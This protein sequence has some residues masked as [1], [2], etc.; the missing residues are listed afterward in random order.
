MRRTLP[1]L[2]LI[3]AMPHA[4]LASSFTEPGAEPA[5]DLSSHE[6]KVVYLDFWA[7]W[8]A[9]CQQSFPWMIELQ[10]RLAERGLVVVT[11][12]VDRD[13][14]KADRFLEKVRSELPVI[15]DPDG[16]LA[17]AYELEAMPSSFL[18]G[19]DGRLVSIHAGFHK[20]GIDAVEA[21]ILEL[22]EK[23]SG[24]AQTP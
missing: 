19:R 13:R 6:G 20:D 12:N 3:L 1:M 11:V 23:E 10:Q 14:V 9:P 16:K 17:A 4:G 2:L 8:C 18:Y 7:S 5:V 24:D 22:L 21:E 15:Y